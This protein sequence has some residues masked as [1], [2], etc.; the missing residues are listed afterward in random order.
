[1][2]LE[3]LSNP[4]GSVILLTPCP[5]CWR[6]S[7]QGRGAV[8]WAGRAGVHV[9]ARTCRATKASHRSSRSCLCVISDQKEGRAAPA[10][11][12]RRLALGTACGCSRERG[13]QHQL[14]LLPL[15]APAQTRGR[16]IPPDFISSFDH[17][18]VCV[19]VSKAGTA[20]GSPPTVSSPLSHAAAQPCGLAKA[21]TTE[22]TAS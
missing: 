1:M 13:Q 5:S 22:G 2:I 15:S 9:W 20:L 16:K 3:V 18:F 11:F 14:R 10:A 21:K 4:N 19:A 6:A 8:S 17:H 7:C 12:P